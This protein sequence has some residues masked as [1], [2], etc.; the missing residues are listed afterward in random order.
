MALKDIVIRG[1]REHNLKGISLQVPR[2]SLVTI[3]GVS[4]SGKSS[5]AFDTIFREGQRRFVE[6]LSAYARQFMGRMDKPRVDHIEGLSPT[7]SIDQHSINR[8]PRS[9]VGT[10]TE[11][12]DCF[13]L[14]YARI[15]V[16]H[17]PVCTKEV[18]AH[19]P[20]RIVD[21]I[22]EHP[23]GT[24]LKILAPVVRGRKGEYRKEL[25]SY[26]LKGFVRARIDGKERR[27]DEKIELSRYKKHFIEI[28][29]DRIVLSEKHRSRVADAVETGLSMTDGL[30]G[31]ESDDVFK[32]F[33]AKLS[34]P[35]CDVDIPEMEPRMFSFNSPQGA[36]PRCSGLG[37]VK[38]L[39]PDLLI[40]DPGLSINQGAI[41]T[42][43]KTGYL[44]YSRLGPESLA[45]VAS[46]FGFSLDQPWST[47]TEKQ[48]NVLLYGSGKEKLRLSFEWESKSSN[49]KV[50]GVDN[51]PIR[52][53]ITTLEDAYRFSRPRHL[54]KFYRTGACPECNGQRLV[55]EALSVTFRGKKITELAAM[56][57]E[58]SGSFFS[59]LNLEGREALIAA[60]LVAE[61]CK[62]LAFLD[63]VGLGYLRL[64]RPASSLSGGE[65]Q[66]VR[67]AAQVGSGLQGVVYILDE[68]SV[69]LHNRD[70]KRLISTLE[71]LRDKGN[72]VFVVEH[73]RDM[74][75]SSDHLVD[76]GPGAGRFGGEIVAQGPM[77]A[78][79]AES[80]TATIAY[81]SGTSEIPVPKKR[82]QLCRGLLTLKGARCY[83][84]KGINVS[85]P[86]GAMIAV[87]GVS[88]SGKS[89][90]VEET[91]V[92]ALRRELGIRRDESI[93]EHDSIEGYERIERVIDID[94]S[95]IGR[96][97]RSNPA[98]YTKVFDL[99]RDVFASCPEAR[100]RGYEKGRFSFNKKGGRCEHCKGAGTIE[101]EMQFLSNVL[102]PCEEC[103]SR[104]YNPETLEILYRGKNI[105]DILEMTVDEALAF[106]EPYPKITRILETLVDV[107]LGYMTL[108]QR[109][110]TLSGG[111]AQRV[112]LASELCRP[113]SGN[114]F[115]VL[116]EP[117]TGL[118]FEDIK[119]LLAAL[120]RLVDAGNTVVIIEHNLDVI[121]NADHVID[122]GPE[123]GEDGGRLV[124]SGTPEEVAAADS[125]MTGE[126]LAPVLGVKRRSGRGNGR[127]AGSPESAG[128]GIASG[129]DPA[130]GNGCRDLVVTGARKN[131]LKNLDVTIPHNSLTVITGLSGSGKSS[132]AFDTI[133]A[134]G[135]RRFVESLSTYARRFLSRMDKVPVE[136]IDGLSPAIAIDQ[137]SAGG[138]P[139]ST[140]ATS[141]EIHDYLRLLFARVGTP[142]CPSCGSRI[143]AWSP[144]AAADDLIRKGGTGRAMIAAPLFRKGFKKELS[145]RRATGFRELAPELLK[146]GFLRV[147]ING[148]EHR[149]DGSGKMPALSNAETI[150]LVVDRVS[151]G[152][153][154]KGRVAESL[155]VAFRQGHGS[156]AVIPV[157]QGEPRLYLEHAGCL[158][159]DFHLGELTPRMF[160]FN[161]HAGACPRC[162]GMGELK[163][164]DPERLIFDPG[165]PLQSGAVKGKVGNWISK[166]GGHVDT[167]LE[168]IG[169]LFDFD[170]Q[171]PWKNLS[172]RAKAAV[173]RG[174][175]IDG[176][177]LTVT[178]K[179]RSRTSSRD[180]TY[181]LKWH[182]VLSWLEQMY[183]RARR[184]WRKFVL[185]RLMHEGVCPEC[186]GGRL[187]PEYLAVTT[188]GRSIK[189][190]C[191]LSIDRVS[192][193][194]EGL[195]FEGTDREVAKEILK[196]IMNRLSFLSEVGLGYLTLDRSS[197]TLSGGEAQRIRLASQ[198][199]NRLVGVLYI[200]DEP[201]IGLHPRDVDRLLN[202]LT[203]LRDL[204]NTVIVVE[205][206]KDS[207]NRADH[208]IDLGPGA[209]RGGGELL[210]SGHPSRI[211]S[212]RRSLTGRYIS[213]EVTAV[214][215]DGKEARKGRDR[216]FLG[217]RSASRHNLKNLDVDFPLQSFTA[218]TGVSGSGKSTLV[219]ELIKEGLAKV[220]KSR[221]EKNP[222]QH[223]IPGLGTVV[224]ARHIDKLVVIDQ[225][226]IGRTPASIPATYT[227]VFA[228]IR[229]LFASTPDA[230]MR[231]FAP[232]HFSFNTGAGR[233]PAC[234]GRGEEV[235]EMH[236][237]SDVVVRCDL[238]RGSRYN[239][240]TLAVTYK[241]ANISDVLDMEV[242]AAATH[243]ENHN[244]IR[245]V[246]DVM[247]DVGLGYLK[248]GQSAKKLSGGEAQRVKLAAELCRPDTG[249]TVYLLDEPTTGLHF[250]DVRRLVNVLRMLVDRDNT[251]IVIEHNLDVIASADHIV[252]LGPEGGD[253]GGELVYAGPPGKAP[254]ELRSHTGRCLKKHMNSMPAKGVR[255]G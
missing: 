235:I 70:N 27:L 99:I 26:R 25:E 100:T 193:F 147:L 127:K 155:E 108:G 190:I 62:R 243:F 176:G 175:G 226:P 140:V 255:A 247:V 63:G 215:H 104:R 49:V 85:F 118:H 205:H 59:E 3:T 202:T 5:L 38:R 216:R 33:S 198:L 74:M 223:T 31:I 96:T 15:G 188:G 34:C 135:Q 105:N 139:R 8:N 1:A 94:Q 248:L 14:Q 182:G 171:T 32:T 42:M 192:E 218:V 123:G 169:K 159:C 24:R 246:L 151:L 16:P 170:R 68:P 157:G 92:R 69:G 67:L 122:L 137:R 184:G 158:N 130:G 217:L 117:T 50:K 153:A 71:E 194:F 73:D 141:T 242:S 230:R 144:A 41:R 239:R 207:I 180:Y 107:G 250:D 57:V 191:S 124:A 48:K 241:G 102:I 51:K 201:S 106:L 234:E 101:V 163:K 82:R 80:D 28:V 181:D 209:G 55:P 40:S 39:D 88:G 95:P 21:R 58:E 121:K 232:G 83:N 227:K 65:A 120:D 150:D 161:S 61:V 87:T 129:A 132:L 114:T 168:A 46:H 18:H 44:A 109:S 116:D 149:L 115:Y 251:V 162:E 6:S 224:G 185:A 195:R 253:A 165:K 86:F 213:G 254:R 45:K 240:E 197:R 244:R 9:T 172:D 133:F 229:D 126:A 154:K 98:T 134:E 56:T 186:N 23:D 164:C 189:E 22:M 200:L 203:E 145:L 10:I 54:E 183:G 20:D 89:T 211:D 196:E 187:K 143:R 166:P 199:G 131:N 72:T 179:R 125:S 222:A 13:R 43:T 237:L 208:L 138:G 245:K 228:P 252:D 204:G 36:C 119:K 136:R 173:L 152:S 19:G 4:G 52:G 233:C 178:R 249:N 30:V 17:C 29:L 79:I 47:L 177:S 128:S 206:D 174:E 110:T 236:F 225:S 231:G 90:L 7:V 60:D 97:P 77:P 221:K 91:L 210:F 113:A 167:A 11:I 81:L 220:L 53:I 37:Q 111:E 103:S 142:H 146:Q 212:C 76:I 75:L 84:L 2:E 238:C 112:K 156:A 66:R 214:C 35:D 64:D 160:S 219:M 93:G 148:K 78:L 12:Y